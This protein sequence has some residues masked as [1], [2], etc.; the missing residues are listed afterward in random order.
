[1]DLIATRIFFVNSSARKLARRRIYYPHWRRKLIQILIILRNEYARRKSL[2][3][4]GLPYVFNEAKSMLKKGV[5]SDIIA[6]LWL[7]ACMG[8][9]SGNIFCESVSGKSSLAHCGC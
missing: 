8:V 3:W 5:R 4:S 2:A 1:M 9:W 7:A 6:N